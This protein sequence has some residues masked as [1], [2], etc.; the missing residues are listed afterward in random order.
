MKDKT[1]Q[2]LTTENEFGVSA[3]MILAAGLRF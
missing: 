1:I 2:G 3:Q